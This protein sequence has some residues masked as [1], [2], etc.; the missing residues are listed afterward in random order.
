MRNRNLCCNVHKPS[1]AVTMK[2]SW[3]RQVACDSFNHTKRVTYG[4][5]TTYFPFQFVLKLLFRT[6]IFIK[7]PNIIAVGW[8]TFL[9]P[10]SWQLWM[11]LIA[12]MIVL[13]LTLS[14][15]RWVRRRCVG[16]IADEF[17]RYGIFHAMFYVATCFCCQGTNLQRNLSLPT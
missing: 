11:A 4:G 2:K 6:Y 13:V 16:H 12:T 14:A 9:T 7:K 8:T 3:P 17:P 5:F 10:Y 15:V 1:S